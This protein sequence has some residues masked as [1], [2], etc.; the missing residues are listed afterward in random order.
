MKLAGV[1]VL[2]NPS[3]DVMDNIK[4]YL[5]S[6]EVLY[7]VDN[8]SCD[9]SEKFKHKKIK[10]ISNGKN[11]GVAKALNIGAK[12][13]IKNGFDFL[14]TMDQDSKFE[15]DTVNQML[16]FLKNAKENKFIEEIIA[17]K[18]E[19]IGLISPYHKTVITKDVIAKGIEMPINV[20]TSGNI[21]NLKAY[22][23]VGGFKDWLF[24]DAVDFEYCLN[25][26]KHNYEIVRLNYLTLSHNLGNPIEKKILSKRI[27]SLNHRPERRYYMVRNIH[28]LNDM[29][30]NDFPDYCHIELMRRWTE[31]VKIILCEKEKIKKIKAM[32]RGYIDYKKGIKGEMK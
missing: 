11:L 7:A 19:D 1:V 23:E 8:S 24:I 6:L 14:L 4:S 31:F 18:Y 28:Y 22:K 13:A 3:D 21:I 9:N 25:L 16:K 5:N 27:Y 12:E 20:M 29:Y 30:K 17:T 2:Y 15:N 32:F 10:Y 26:R